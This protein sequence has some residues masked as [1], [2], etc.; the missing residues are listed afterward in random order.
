MDTEDFV[1]EQM[2]VNNRDGFVP[3]ALRDIADYNSK[4]LKEAPEPA[5]TV[6]G[7][8]NDFYE[9]ID[10]PQHESTAIEEEIDDDTWQIS[11]A[12]FEVEPEEAP[13]RGARNRRAPPKFEYDDLG[14]PKVSFVHVGSRQQA[15][16]RRMDEIGRKL[17]ELLLFKGQ[18]WCSNASSRF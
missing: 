11:D 4:G 15:H 6:T 1:P 8:I 13:R 10:Q 5:S 16:N 18:G 7:A 12:Y 3:R 17:S 14:N 2:P 9:N